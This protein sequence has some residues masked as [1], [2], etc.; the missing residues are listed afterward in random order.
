[1]TPNPNLSSR[2]AAL[3][4]SFSPPCLLPSQ[5]RTLWT[6]PYMVRPALLRKKFGKGNRLL[7]LS[8]IQHRPYFYLVWID[9]TWTGEPDAEDDLLR[10]HLDAIYE[11]IEE[12][13]GA[14]GEGAPFKWPEADLEGGTTWWSATDDDVMSPRTRKLLM[15]PLPPAVNNAKEAA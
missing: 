13:F 5:R 3:T 12:E 4:S 6:H 11:A 2:L 15:T 10:N 1:M 9:D 8:P 14:R 7:A